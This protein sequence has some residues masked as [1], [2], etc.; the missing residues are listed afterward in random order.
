M[1]TAIRT[2][3]SEEATPVYATRRAAITIGVLFI[4]A[5]VSA[6]L[7]LLLYGPILGADYLVRGA[8]GKNQV[9]LGAIMELILVVTA[10]GTAIGLFPILRR[11]GERIALAHLSFRFLEAVMISVGVVAVLSLLTLSQEFVATVGVDASVF[12]VSGSLLHAVREWTLIL[13][14]LLFLGVNTLMYSS[15]L[16]KSRLVPRPLASM[17]MIGAVLV[18]LAAFL[19]MF[20]IVPP[21]TPISGLLSAPIAVFEMLLAGWLIVKGFSSPATASEPARTVTNKLMA[22]A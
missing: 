22:A 2:A 20:D 4:L 13:G 3:A 18:M 11:Y 7:G 10:I 14:P 9:I 21:F 6:I 12:R 5:T 1:T 19:A 8:E 17:G 15:L 16:F